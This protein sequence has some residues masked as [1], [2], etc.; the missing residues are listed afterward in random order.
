MPVWAPI[1]FVGTK[2]IAGFHS[3]GPRCAHHVALE[4]GADQPGYRR[5]GRLRGLPKRWGL[6]RAYMRAVGATE[7]TNRSSLTAF[8]RFHRRTKI[9][10]AKYR[11]VLHR[12]VFEVR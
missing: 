4:A 8:G 11:G 6:L 5:P 3:P 7:R 12:R 2:C 9:H 10:L 1:L